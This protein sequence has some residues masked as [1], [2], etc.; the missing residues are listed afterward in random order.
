MQALCFWCKLCMAPWR[1]TIFFS[2]RTSRCK[3][4]HG[5]TSSQDNLL[6]NRPCLMFLRW[7]CRKVCVLANLLTGRKYYSNVSFCNART[8]SSDTLPYCRRRKFSVD[9]RNTSK[10]LL[11]PAKLVPLS[12][13]SE[14][15]NPKPRVLQRLVR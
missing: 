15:T 1:C 11:A 4:T 8:S 7:I 2:R 13:A 5:K 3:T 9:L 10:L 6:D 12:Q 14:L